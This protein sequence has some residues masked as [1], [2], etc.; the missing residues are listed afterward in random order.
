MRASR[1]RARRRR[2]KQ[3]PSRRT[4][5]PRGCCEGEERRSGGWGGVAVRR[6]LIA[7]RS[8]AWRAL[9]VDLVDLLI[10]A[11]IDLQFALR[12]L[13]G[14]QSASGDLLVDALVCGVLQGRGHI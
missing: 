7:A 2:N 1:L 11:L 12:G 3:Q 6:R 5:P 9:L 10:D 8:S 13:V 14:G 4:D